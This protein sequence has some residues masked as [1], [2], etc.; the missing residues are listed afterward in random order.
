MSADQRPEPAAPRGAP[1]VR[2]T[3]G[4]SF[5]RKIPP[6]SGEYH[7]V[8]LWELPLRTMHWV[9][10]ACIV[11]LAVTGFYI[12]K[13]YFLTGGEASSHFLMGKVRLIH[14]ATAGV[15]VAT[16]IV[17][18][19][20]LFM[21]NKFERLA[22]LFPVR[23]RDWVNMVQQVKFYLMIQPEKAPHYLGHNPLQQLSYTGMYLIALLVA[24]T[25]FTLYG[26]SAPGGFFFTVTT[27]VPRLFGGLQK[28]RF[29]HHIS[30]WAFLAFIPIHVYLAMRA[31]VLER[32]GTIS[33]IISGGR[34]VRSDITYVDE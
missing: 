34:F 28:V 1:Q 20:W 3:P 23:P 2:E 25:G 13:P 15:L 26:Q 32:T 24:V 18:A 8:L 4:W 5:A 21:G 27:W 17:R 9:A 12:G 29:F 22:A 16:A 14:F 6:P 10:A 19:Y 31:D 7:W 30:I 33:S 11:V